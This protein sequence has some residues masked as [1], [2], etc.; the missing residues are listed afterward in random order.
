MSVSKTMRFL[1]KKKNLEIP[2]VVTNVTIIYYYY[3]YFLPLLIMMAMHSAML[4][5]TI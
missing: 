3:Y 5:Q 1:L 2:A 4:C